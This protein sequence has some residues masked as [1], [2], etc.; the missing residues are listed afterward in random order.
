MTLSNI[1]YY[2][3]AL[4]MMASVLI[5]HLLN[6]NIDQKPNGRISISFRSSDFLM[7]SEKE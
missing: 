5:A 2:I 7:K 6:L 3:I 4:A 1:Y